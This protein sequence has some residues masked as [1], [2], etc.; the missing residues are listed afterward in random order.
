MPFSLTNAPA[1]FQHFMNNIFSDML[2]VC[3][4][5]YLDN[6]EQHHK[7]VCEVL[8][9]HLKNHLYAYTD[10]CNFHTNSVEYLS[11]MLSMA[12][13]SMADYK[14][15]TIQ[16]MPKLHKVKKIQSFLGFAGAH[17]LSGGQALR[18]ETHASVSHSHIPP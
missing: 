3:I 7:H 15:K 5:I 1:A 11:Y 4:L 18:R 17:L 2:N 8:W 9:H 14:V 6:M 13:L 12:D 10:K 16:E